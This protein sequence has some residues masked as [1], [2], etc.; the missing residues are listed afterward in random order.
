MEILELLKEKCTRVHIF[1]AYTHKIKIIRQK[2]MKKKKY[3]KAFN[4]M[5]RAIKAENMHF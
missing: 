2:E 3:I 1:R 5:Q 4:S